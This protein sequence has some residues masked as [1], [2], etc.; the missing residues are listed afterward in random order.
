[1]AKETD[2]GYIG[3]EITSLPAEIGQLQNLKTLQASGNWR[4]KYRDSYP[5]ATPGNQLSA[6]L[7]EIGQLTS[8]QRLDIS[9]NQLS[10]LPPEIGQL[11]S[12]RT[13]YLS[14][15]Q[16]SALPP[17][18]GQLTSLQRLDISSNQ[19]SA[20]PPEIGQLTSLQ[21]LDIS[22]NQ[23]S[24]LP[25]EIGQLTSL[26]TLYLS[27]NQLSVLPHQI[28]RLTSLQTLYLSS[29]QLSALPPEIGQLTNLTQ[30]D[31]RSNQLS[32]L[33]PE[34][35]QLTNLTQLDSRSNQL[36]ALPPEIGQ[37][38]NLTQL[39]SRSN[40]LSALPPEI[41]QLTNL[42]QLDSR[43][44]Q[45][46][47][48]PPEIGQ[49]T[50]LQTLYLSSNQLSA[51]PPEIGQLTSLQTLYLSSNQLSVLP[52]EIVQL[53]SLQKLDLSS[54]QLSVLPP[55]IVQLTSLQKLYLGSNQ[56]S[57]LPPEIVQLTSLQTLY[58]RSNQLSALPP[59]IGQLSSLQKL[60]LSENQ[61]SALPPEIVQLTSLQR[62]YLGSNQLSTLPPEIVQL[63]SLHRL[64]L[65][66]NRLS[67]LPP[68]IGQLSSLQ[69]LY[70]RYNR[71]SA[72]PPE[73]GQLT[74]LQSLYL[75]SNQ[76]SA[77]PP[78]IV[79]LTS[80]QSLSLSSNQLSALQPGIG[81]LTNLT[82]LDLS[83]NQL[84]ALP[85]EIGQL[86]N[87]TQ[88]D[89]SSNQ[90]SALPPEIGQLTSL[91]TLSLS[92]NQLSVLQPE[93]G[94]LTNLT[95]LDLSSNQLSALP[96]EIK[97][98]SKLKKLDLRGNPIPV[99]PE[100]LGSKQSREDPGDIATILEYYFRTLDPNETEPLF[101]AK[102]IIVGEPEAGKTTL[103]NKL[104]NSNFKLSTDQDSTR[105]IDVTRWEF[106]HPS[107][108]PF[109][110]SIWD[111][112]GQDVYHNIH[113]FF[114]T[115]RSLYGLLVDTRR[116]NPDLYY[117]LNSIQLLGGASPVLLIKNEKQNRS[118]TV[119]EGEL[120]RDFRNLKES[121]AT[122]LADNR[123]LEAI[124]TTVQQYI[125]R[126]DHVDTPWPKTWAR[127]R[128]AIENDSRD[129]LAENA[130]FD[131][132]KINGLSDRDDMRRLSQFLHDL[133]ICLHFQK[134][135]TLKRWVIL[136]PEWATNAVYKIIDSKTVQDKQG[137]FTEADLK[138][139]W[140]DGQYA[141]MHD[142]LLEL[143][144]SFKL[145]YLIPPKPDQPDTYIAPDLLPLEA[146]P[147]TWD[148]NQNLLLRYRYEFMPKGILTRFIVEMH[149]FIE[150][151]TLVWKSGAVLNNGSARAEVIELYHKGEI[152]IRVSGVRQKD[153][154][155]VIDHEFEKIHDTYDRLRYQTLIPCN[156]ST[157]NGS[158]E[159]HFYDL[160]A[161]HKRITNRKQTV[162]CDKPPYE[163]VH[164]RSLIDDITDFAPEL[165]LNEKEY[166]LSDTVLPS[167]ERMKAG[168]AEQTLPESQQYRMALFD[169]LNTLPLPQFEKL[170]FGL[171]VPRGNLG[172]ATAAQGIRVSKLL[173]WA[174]SD[175]GCGLKAVEEAI[176]ALNSTS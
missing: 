101:E 3:N 134:N 95:Q 16:L 79:Q 2:D 86:T 75:S 35:G 59:E 102:F 60:D 153:L 5:T 147:Y 160:E 118:C 58:L 124:K 17:E 32:A 127:M 87:L 164:V 149:K 14:S 72:L 163:D 44:N 55:E 54:N 77:L 92:S 129:Y 41:G 88:L 70:L 130:F 7:P 50:S 116:E 93:I 12:L 30:L 139:I 173:E 115:E 170:V 176:A 56:L 28:G 13:L 51:L 141:D 19:L 104:L 42:T 131:L 9:S 11:T 38:T 29:N 140:R 74:S 45:L 165:M 81:Q 126:L 40:Q 6:L 68:E 121:L 31:S 49:L 34:I 146:P 166:I 103:A 67:A 18:I 82:Q 89:L 37:L 85:P 138:K 98:L 46:S 100:I 24:A 151:Q 97:Q 144:K 33:P 8:L 69:K 123:G 162:E 27:S 125:T 145:C 122:N 57:V 61:L 172:D 119:R 136:K 167:S 36:S 47:A 148:N 143:M 108:H 20:L 133:G 137:C 120:R 152:Q 23:L 109:F 1:M 155:T 142:E 171:Q 10:A 128:A 168:W 76:L 96:P 25:P 78:E 62:L 112:G 63:S 161:L 90:L 4:Y 39:D 80:L 158:Q 94:Q 113:Q 174:E 64:D 84:S 21:R 117:W 154:I 73:I 91:Q 105:G 15:N 157:C 106:I 65:R 43:S 52:P 135:S 156:C 114:L 26:Q 150:T 111:F 159:P 99:P 132:C 110:V 66:Y 71:L 175:M 107:G 22:S 83:S 53:T 48:L 169:G